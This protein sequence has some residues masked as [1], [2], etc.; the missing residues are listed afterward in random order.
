MTCT[1]LNT[2]HRRLLVALASSLVLIATACGG[3]DD[4]D[5]TSTGSGGNGGTGTAGGGGSGGTSSGTATGT[6]SGTGTGTPGGMGTGGADAC[7][8]YCGDNLANCTGDNAQW[9]GADA[10]G[11]C[12]ATC[13]FFA[14]GMEGDT[15][16]DTLGC[17]QTQTDDA[18]SDPA[19]SCPAS[20]PYG[21]ATCGA[22]QCQ[23][24]CNLIQ[25]V[26][27]GGNE[28]YGSE[29]ECLAACAL[30]PDATAPYTGD[31]TAI[32]NTFAC[33]GYH[34]TAAAVDP[35]THCVHAGGQAQPCM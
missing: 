18:A 25:S 23:V 27:V 16:G 13:G 3:D 24:F 4:G 10:Q 31:E 28:Q 29:A 22:T 5:T 21:A 34:L 8:T 14:P 19:G 7:Q 6:A 12:E 1:Y 2:T 33:R 26:C 15:S 9:V 11:F 20:G 30:L 32:G 17:R 35:D